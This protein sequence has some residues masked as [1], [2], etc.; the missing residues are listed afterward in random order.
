MTT[1]FS[2]NS[3]FYDNIASV[4]WFLVQGIPGLQAAQGAG[5]G[6]QNV[7]MVQP[8]QNSMTS[9]TSNPV[10]SNACMFD[11]HLK[12][13]INTYIANILFNMFI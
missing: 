9:M 11:D 10:A 4:V 6:Q 8:S 2:H 13:K 12:K 3:T 7:V 1:E 5:G